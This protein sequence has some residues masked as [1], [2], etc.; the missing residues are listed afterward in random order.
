MTTSKHIKNRL[1]KACDGKHSHQH[2][3]GKVKLDGSWDPR[4]HLAQEYPD[5]FCR[6]V[7]LGIQDEQEERKQSRVTHSVLAIEDL[8][9]GD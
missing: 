2:V 5:D 9:C 3:M 4:S 7:C 1:W 8:G 6:A